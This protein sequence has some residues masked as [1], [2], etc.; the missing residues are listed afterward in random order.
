MGVDASFMPIWKYKV[1]D[2]QTPLE[3]SGLAPGRTYTYILAE[4]ALKRQRSPGLVARWRAKRE[5]KRLAREVSAANG[6]QAISWNDEGEIVYSQQFRVDHEIKSYLW[7]WD[8]RD[9]FG[10]F[11]LPIEGDES[12]RPFWATE[13]ERC[14]SFPHLSRNSYYNDYFLPVDFEHVAEVEPYKI[15]DTWTGSKRV[16]STPRAWREFQTI[17][18]QLRVPSQYEW[19]EADPLSPVRA[20]FLQLREILES[21]QRHGLPVIFW[22]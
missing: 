12:A 18:E 7:W 8:R 3:A 4:G 15:F 19:D 11:K 14:P 21:S 5:V 9:L 10:D 2:F 17:N 16:G 6:G 1:G 22:G 13:P 20:A